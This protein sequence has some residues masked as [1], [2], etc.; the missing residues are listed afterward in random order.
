VQARE[1]WKGVDLVYG[2]RNGSPAPD[3]PFV[4]IEE[5]THLS[6]RP[7]VPP[8][9]S[10]LVRGTYGGELQKNGIYMLITASTEDLVLEAA[11]ALQPVD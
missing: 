2:G 11:R 4:E 6:L 10:I 8:E 3:T 5:Q 7:A 9:G 1:H